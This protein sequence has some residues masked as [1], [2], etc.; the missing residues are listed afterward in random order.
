MASIA[1]WTYI[2]QQSNTLSILNWNHQVL[3]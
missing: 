2:V 1:P 3:M